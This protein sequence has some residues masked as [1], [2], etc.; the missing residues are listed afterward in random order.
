[1]T[2]NL[3]FIFILCC[4]VI[5]LISYFRCH[6]KKE[7]GLLCGGLAFTVLAD[8]FLVLRDM[9][10]FGVA[11]F[12]FAHVCYIFR[13]VNLKNR[14]ILPIFGL[15]WVFGFVSGSVIVFAGL[16]AC[17]FGVNIYVN[18]FKAHRPKFN[19]YLVAAGLILFAL[20]DIN[21]MLFSLPRYVGM[22]IFFPYAFTLIWVFYLPAQFLLAISAVRIKSE[23]P[24]YG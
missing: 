5:A 18:L 13:A 17:L 16:Y 6:S 11:A 9:H 15:V 24:V 7:W 20:C 14:W 8:Y 3:K 21:V 22:S 19:Y 12:C 10:L 1:M 23:E 2:P 4:L